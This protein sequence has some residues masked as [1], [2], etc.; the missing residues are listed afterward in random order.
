[1]N[2]RRLKATIRSLNPC[3]IYCMAQTFMPSSR[4]TYTISNLHSHLYVLKRSQFDMTKTTPHFPHKPFSFKSNTVPP[5]DQWT[6]QSFVNLNSSHAFTFHVRSV[7]NSCS[8]HLQNRAMHDSTSV[9]S[10]AV[11]SQVD[12]C[13]SLLTCPPD[14]TLGF[15]AVHSHPA[16]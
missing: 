10:T 2:Y 6:R 8:L 11:I 3:F 5:V 4:L 1:M 9:T 12:C 7:R 16:A 13:G 14:F 15:P